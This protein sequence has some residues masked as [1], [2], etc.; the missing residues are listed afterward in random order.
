MNTPFYITGGTLPANA[1]CYVERQADRDLLQALLDA[2]FCYVLDTRQVGKSSLIERTARKLRER[3][4]MVAKIDLTTTGKEVTA[5]QWY[6]GMLRQVADSLNTAGLPDFWDELRGFWRENSELGPMQRWV[7]ALR[8]VVLPHSDANLVIFVDEIEN[9]RNFNFTDEFFAGIRACYNRRVDEPMMRRL[10]FCLAGSSTPDELI[11]SVTSTP[12]NVGLGITLSDFTPQEA[13]VLEQGLSDKATLARILHW[14][15]GHPYLTQKLCAEITAMGESG[16]DAVDR[17]CERLFFSPEARKSEKNLAFVAKRILDSPLDRAAL[18]DLYSRVRRGGVVNDEK[19]SL[20]STLRLSGIARARNGQLEVR[21]RI[22]E[23]VFDRDWIRENMPDAELRR[24]KATAR[25]VGLS[26]GGVAAAVV[27]LMSWLTF[28][29]VRAESLANSNAALAQSK[30]LEATQSA[31]DAKQS[32]NEAHQLAAERA[33]AL[34]KAN[35][36]KTRADKNAAE[37]QK[38]AQEALRQETSAKTLAQLYQ[39]EQQNARASEAEAKKQTKMAERFNYLGLIN[40]AQKEID[41]GNFIHAEQLLEATRRSPERAF[42]WYYLNDLCHPEIRRFNTKPLAYWE[43]DSAQRISIS[44]NKNEV[45]IAG[46]K[47]TKLINTTSGQVIRN[48]GT[49]VPNYVAFLPNGTETLTATARKITNAKQKSQNE[50]Q[51][52]L[53]LWDTITGK[54]IR[55]FDRAEQCRVFTIAHNGSAVTS[56]TSRSDTDRFAGDVQVWSVTTGKMLTELS[57]QRQPTT[58]DKPSARILTTALSPDGTQLLV[59]EDIHIPNNDEH[60]SYHSRTRI[61]Y[62]NIAKKQKLWK[63][64]VEGYDGQISFTPDS[65][66][67]ILSLTGAEILALNTSNGEKLAFYPLHGRSAIL[68]H[69]GNI[70]AAMSDDGVRLYELNSGKIR[71]VLPYSTRQGRLAFSQDDS[72]LVVGASNGQITV[73][74]TILGSERLRLRGHSS[75]VTEIAFSNDNRR[76][77]S[78]AETTRI[79]Y[80]TRPRMGHLYSTASPRDSAKFVSFVPTVP[81]ALYGDNSSFFAGLLSVRRDVETLRSLER[82]LAVSPDGNWVVSAE[83][84][85]KNNRKGEVLHLR[86]RNRKSPFAQNKILNE[87]WADWGRLGDLGQCSFT[88]DGRFIMAIVPGKPSGYAL[89][90]WNVNTGKPAGTPI[91]NV[92]ALAPNG[93]FALFEIPTSKQSRILI[94]RKRQDLKMRE[95]TT[96]RAWQVGSFDGQGSLLSFDGNRIGYNDRRSTFIRDGRTGRLVSQLTGHTDYVDHFAFSSDARRIA[97]TGHDKTLRIWDTESGRILLTI[98]TDD[99]WANP[100]FSPDGSDLVRVGATGRLFLLRKVQQRLMETEDKKQEALNKKQ[101]ATTLND[102]AW[103]V[104]DPDSKFKPSQENI[105][106]AIPWQKEPLRSQIAKMRPF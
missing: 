87:S 85:M 19:D 33:T 88:P 73:F 62:W 104:V 71:K 13:A 80:A 66:S 27:A 52:R 38:K 75:R 105:L 96:R 81:S 48:F 102:A 50:T 91:T 82:N 39:A 49:E 99:T 60:K 28:R 51:T 54:R 2:Q 84:A 78:L 106:A 25:R 95:L 58:N 83:F 97:T 79:W 8:A 46:D 93:R 37:A 15:N 10:S 90:Y 64:E 35:E 72:Q 103:K 63:T 61:T 31:A 56:F 47:G 89:Q 5:A 24:Q 12:F 70:I 20:Q 74:D 101:M 16:S 3:G 34:N 4:V 32:A 22:Y 30:T 36:E 7:E 41:T 14:T 21:N 100:V 40:V 9:V 43:D 18:L 57:I 11:H 67:V 68:S 44:P 53:E 26:I 55:Q 86:T 92:I 23:R 77:I 59:V 17:L 42:E 6:N 94:K 98:D 69:D 1:P 76:I 45:L 65:K 29:A